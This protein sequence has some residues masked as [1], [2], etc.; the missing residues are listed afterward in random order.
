MKRIYAWVPL[1]LWMSI[2]FFLSSRS[3]VQISQE[4]SVNFLIFKTLHI[5]EYG[6]LYLLVY[7]AIRFECPRNSRFFWL[8]AAFVVSVLYAGSDEIHQTLIPTREG[9]ARDVIIDGIGIILS[10]V[11]LQQFVP[12]LPRKLRNLARNWLLVQSKNGNTICP[13]YLTFFVYTEIWEQAKQRSPK[14]LRKDWVSHPECYLRHFS[15]RN[16]TLPH[17]NRDS[18][19]IWI[20]I[21]WNRKC[22]LNKFA[23]L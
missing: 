21:E 3:R 7:R 17:L 16:V 11:T 22:V 15:F 20:F 9:R 12:S 14:V 4:E 8:Y 18:S 13:V 5:I 19:I 2:I 23:L 10:W 6:L 1:L